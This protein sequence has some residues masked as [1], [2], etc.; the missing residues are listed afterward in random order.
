MNWFIF[1]SLGITR[2]QHDSYRNQ[3]HVGGTVVQL[4]QACGNRGGT[5]ERTPQK[6]ADGGGNGLGMASVNWQWIILLDV[7]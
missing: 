7:Y 3:K 6:T 2:R 5:G 4:P 1:Y